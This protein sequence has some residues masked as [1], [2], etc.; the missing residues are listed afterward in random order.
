MGQRFAHLLTGFGQFWMVG[1]IERQH[2][3]ND[4]LDVIHHTDGGQD[5]RGFIG[6]RTQTFLIL[7]SSLDTPFLLAFYCG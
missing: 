2:Q 5:L 7:F 4:L 6:P 3:S 1:N